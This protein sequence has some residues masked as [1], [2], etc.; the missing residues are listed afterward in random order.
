[1]RI[2]RHVSINNPNV[3]QTHNVE[4]FHVNNFINNFKNV[5][6]HIRQ[7]QLVK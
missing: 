4:M 2:Q 1:M 3:S 7:S 5:I 6:S